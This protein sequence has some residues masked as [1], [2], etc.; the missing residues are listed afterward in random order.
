MYFFSKKIS[1]RKSVH[2]LTMKCKF[3]ILLFLGLILTFVQS[4]TIQETYEIE[5]I[6][7]NAD[8]TQVFGKELAVEEEDEDDED[9]EVIAKI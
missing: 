7:N 3:I 2:F 5:E 9:E 4:R 8:E 6:E 1:V